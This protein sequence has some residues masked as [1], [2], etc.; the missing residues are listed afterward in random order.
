MS[1]QCEAD[2]IRE[3]HAAFDDEQDQFVGYWRKIHG[4][5]YQAGMPDVLC[6]LEDR[7]ALTEFKFIKD[8]RHA[9]QPFGEMVRSVATSRQSL[10]LTLCAA[11]D[12]PLRSRVVV[13]MPVEFDQYGLQVE[14]TFA[15]G[16]D[17]IDTR[18]I[19]Q[20]MLTLATVAIQARLTNFKSDGERPNPWRDWPAN[21]QGQVK[22]R[23]DKW[24][25]S[26]LVLGVESWKAGNVPHAGGLL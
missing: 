1:A 17:W 22:C 19:T 24:R 10:D 2:L 20:S 14:G 18:A 6:A 9:A 23:G 16:V 26:P 12:G 8:N 11:L 4:E 13:G 3:L 15:I 5:L 25:A 21:V 7:A